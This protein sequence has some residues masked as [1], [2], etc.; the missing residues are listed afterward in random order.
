MLLRKKSRSN[1]HRKF[2]VQ[3]IKNTRKMNVDYIAHGKLHYDL[4]GPILSLVSR[5][6]KVQ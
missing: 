4:R 1:Q 6:G 5:R 2:H 3:F